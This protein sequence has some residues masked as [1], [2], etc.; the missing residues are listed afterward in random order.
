MT[1]SRDRPVLLVTGGAGLVA[2][3]VRPLLRRP[4]RVLRVLDLRAPADGVR[5]VTRSWR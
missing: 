5:G 2:G 3:L 1:S 4:D